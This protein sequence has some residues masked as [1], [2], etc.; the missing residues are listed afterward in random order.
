MNSLPWF[1]LPNTLSVRA[2]AITILSLWIR[3]AAN[4]A[5]TFPDWSRWEQKPEK[6]VFLIIEIRKELNELYAYRKINRPKFSKRF[7]TN[8]YNITE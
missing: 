6:K 4:M 7:Q 2:L 5:A 3:I 1:V 8:M